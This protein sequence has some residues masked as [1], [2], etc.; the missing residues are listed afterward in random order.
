MNIIYKIETP[1]EVNVRYCG[2]MKGSYVITY[3]IKENNWFLKLFRK[4][5]IKQVI[6]YIQ[7]AKNPT[8]KEQELIEMSKRGVL[9]SWGFKGTV[10][11][12]LNEY[13]EIVKLC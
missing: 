8:P 10:R 9:V 11:E 5:K 3:L 12:A 4:Y 6:P 2:E 7:N 1:V 13:P